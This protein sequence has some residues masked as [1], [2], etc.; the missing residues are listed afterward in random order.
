MSGTVPPDAGADGD[1]ELAGM[2]FSA[3][4]REDPYPLYRDVEIPGCRHAA[5]TAM[6]K[7]PR[8]APPLLDEPSTGE[9]MWTT[10]GRWL[11]NLDGDRHTQMRKRFSRIFT[12]RSV[13]AYRTAIE[14]KAA[15]LIDAVVEAGEMDLVSDFARPLPF[16]IITTVLGVPEERR[17]WLADRMLVLDT[18]FARRHEP[19]FVERGSEAVREMLDYLAGLLAER[20]DRPRDDLMSILAADVPADEEGRLD[21]LANCV[22]FVE[23]GHVTTTSLIT[24][25]LLLLLRNP[26]QLGRLR[27]DPEL[28]P[29]AVEEMLRMVSPVT[30]V[31]CR[32]REDVDIAGYRFS[33]GDQR[34]V[35]LPGADRDPEV[36]AD[37]DAFDVTRTPNPHV[38]FSAGAHFCLGA[39]L[40]RLH[41]EVAIGTILQ[42]LP[43]IR[44]AGEPRWLS[45][46]PVREPVSLP[47]AW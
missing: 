32:A 5:A 38:A 28:V 22:F 43:G 47:V 27:D 39:P 16:S 3:A 46:I 18:A 45:A 31:M 2:L 35:F 9:L 36:F 20:V 24:G 37:P 15:T 41:G 13:E 33:R 6:L 30:V 29:T 34:L 40:A 4:G 14:A 19:G 25:G 17:Q 12:P 7:D 42:R 26:D 10:F 21:L 23:A 1:Q 44:L 11:L 8:T